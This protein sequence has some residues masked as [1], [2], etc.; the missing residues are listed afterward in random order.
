MEDITLRA[1]R[2]LGEV[3][4]V[5]AED[6]RTTRRLLQHYEISAP[7]TSFHDFTAPGKVR[8]LVSRLESGEDLALVSEAGMPG[9][10]DPGYALVREALAAGCPI[11]CVP[12][13]SAVL[14]ALVLSGLPSHSF[15]FVGFLPRRSGER[16]RF[17]ARLAE[18]PETIV[19]FE[20][21]HRALASLREIVACMGA[22][23][24]LAVGRELTKRF[25][26]MFRGTA[27]GALTHFEAMAPRGELTLV[28]GG[29]R[30]PLFEGALEREA[31]RAQ[32]LA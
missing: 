31:G 21:P 29:S 10:S 22:D 1:L 7:V 13:P 30:A 16:R 20:S 8:R 2:I 15:L 9:V 24:P 18:Q 28:I 3:S 6:T 5:A 14:T 27:A 11:T 25:E 26:E 17:L 23:R 19:A 4:L 12:G 32:P